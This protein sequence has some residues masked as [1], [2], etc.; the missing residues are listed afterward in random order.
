MATKFS[1]GGYEVKL[2][3]FIRNVPIK[4]SLMTGGYFGGLFPQL[5]VWA[6]FCAVIITYKYV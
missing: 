5:F 3:N 6:Y 4:R 1:A 2:H